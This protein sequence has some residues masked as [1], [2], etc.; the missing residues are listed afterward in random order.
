M[1]APK[2]RKGDFIKKIADYSIAGGMSALVILSLMGCENKNY[3][4]TENIGES[5]SENKQ[6]HLVIIEQD[7]AGNFKI[8]EEYTSAINLVLVK[9]NAENGSAE[10]ILNDNEQIKSYISTGTNANLVPV[11]ASS[12]IGGVLGYWASSAVVPYNREIYYSNK[13]TFDRSK[14]VYEKDEKRKSTYVGSGG[15][16]YMPASSSYSPSIAR[17]TGYFSSS[18]HGSSAGNGSSSG[19]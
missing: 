19:G 7:A 10:Y 17:S 18:G 8:V 2:N 4:S 9:S 11:I 3:E 12:V 15:Y 6:N 14:Y 1:I 5:F 13:N 16:V